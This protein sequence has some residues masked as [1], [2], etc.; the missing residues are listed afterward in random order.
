VTSVGRDLVLATNNR[1]KVREMAHA[2]QGLPLRLIPVAELGDWPEPEETGATLEENA[3]LKARAALERTGRLCLADD[4]GLEVEALGGAPGVHSSRYA[5]SDVTYAQNVEKLLRELAEV[6]AERRQARFRCVIA[7]VEPGGRKA[8][9]EGIV[10]GRIR[11]EACGDGGFGYD[12]VF[13]VPETGRTFAEMTL[14]EK[15]GLSHRGR[16]LAAVRRI[17]ETWY[18]G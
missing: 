16:A 11:F 8:T 7:L 3:L 1:D 18:G 2:L 14:A 4:T 12:P 17:L 13:W 9:V 15:D 6:P 10:E 5:G